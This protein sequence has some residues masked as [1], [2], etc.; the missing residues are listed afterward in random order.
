LEHRE[1]RIVYPY[2]LEYIIKS[3]TGFGKSWLYIVEFFEVI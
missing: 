3:S 1:C 2:P